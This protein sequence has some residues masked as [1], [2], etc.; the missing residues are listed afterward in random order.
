MILDGNFNVKTSGNVTKSIIKNDLDLCCSETSELILFAL[1]ELFLNDLLSEDLIKNIE[2]E[3]KNYFASLIHCAIAVPSP[4]A[5]G[6]TEF[7]FDKEQI[8]I[9]LLKSLTQF[10]KDYSEESKILKDK[11]TLNISKELPKA[12]EAKSLLSNHQT[13]E[14]I[15]KSISEEICKVLS[16]KGIDPEAIKIAEAHL[17]KLLP[18]LLKTISESKS[19]PNI[20]QAIVQ[21]PNLPK[22]I[23]QKLYANEPTT[24]SEK[25]KKDNIPSPE[26]LN[27]IDIAA[28]LLAQFAEAGDMTFPKVKGMIQSQLIYYLSDSKPMDPLKLIKMGKIFQEVIGKRDRE[29]KTLNVQAEELSSEELK[30]T[31]T[32]LFEAISD[33]NGSSSSLADK[34]VNMVS[35]SYGGKIIE[36]FLNIILS[37][38]LVNIYFTRYLFPL[39]FLPALTEVNKNNLPSSNAPIPANNLQIQQ[40]TEEVQKEAFE[41]AYSKE[42]CKLITNVMKEYMFDYIFKQDID[43]NK[44]IKN[45]LLEIVDKIVSPELKKTASGFPSKEMQLLSL[46]L[47]SALP[48]FLSDYSTA[49]KNLENSPNN[50]HSYS[51]RKENAILFEMNKIRRQ[52][53]L[54]L[55]AIDETQQQEKLISLTRMLMAEDKNTKGNMLQLEKETLVKIVPLLVNRFISIMLEPKSIQ[56]F[57]KEFLNKPESPAAEKIAYTPSSPDYSKEV[58]QEWMKVMQETLFALCKLLN[59]DLKNKTLNSKSIRKLFDTLNIINILPELILPVPHMFEDYEGR[60]SNIRLLNNL[61]VNEKQGSPKARI[62]WNL[63]PEQER[64]LK[65]ELK[66]CIENKI[67]NPVNFKDII[68]KNNINI[69]IG[70][71]NLAEKIAPFADEVIKQTFGG[72]YDNSLIKGP[73]D[74]LLELISY[75]KLMRLFFYEYIVNDCSDDI[76]KAIHPNNTL[77]SNKMQTKLSSDQFLSSF[78][79]SWSFPNSTIPI[80]DVNDEKSIIN[81]ITDQKLQYNNLQVPVGIILDWKN[82]KIIEENFS[83]DLINNISFSE[84]FIETTSSLLISFKK[85]SL[86]TENESDLLTYLLKHKEAPLAYYYLDCKLNMNEN[87]LGKVN[88]DIKVNELENALALYVTTPTLS[89]LFNLLR[90]IQLKNNFNSWIASMKLRYS[91]DFEAFSQNLQEDLEGTNHGISIIETTLKYISDI[92]TLSFNDKVIVKELQEII[93]S[94]KVEEKLPIVLS[95]LNQFN[96]WK[97]TLDKIHLSWEKENE[98]TPQILMDVRR[99]YENFSNLLAIIVTPPLSNTLQISLLKTMRSNLDRL[100]SLNLSLPGEEDKNLYQGQVIGDSK[101]SNA[102]KLN[103]IQQAKKKNCLLRLLLWRR[104]F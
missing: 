82:K 8:Q 55:M 3:I 81:T 51:N 95:K 14:Q 50:V 41:I 1:K 56:I 13:N 9:K 29:K 18:I 103:L 59:V 90:N 28:G 70:G 46:K 102:I 67:K 100:L 62:Q 104:V 12:I 94:T 22:E 15:V 47:I 6:K 37:P 24:S 42:G 49:L 87:E 43:L 57:L 48:S 33:V 72:V 85:R 36:N 60:L 23:F 30:K 99:F 74:S 31:S 98:I 45:I 92:K 11:Q 97:N 35:S 89:P 26:L 53:G 63:E 88:W 19:V 65:I 10:L 16:L 21:Q 86:I 52:R 54:P 76:L 69:S 17:P 40:R 58:K 79:L 4:N 78:G 7:K 34:F 84:K 61:L 80:V 66:N 27:E 68:K 32:L 96:L 101:T 83:R 20:I 38:D 5:T 71:I 77:Y 91:Q 64:Q 25:V 2:V 39:V 75:K 93:N 44:E 73:L